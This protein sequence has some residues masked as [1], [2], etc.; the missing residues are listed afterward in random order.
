MK[1][2]LDENL[3][4]KLVPALQ[5]EG[6][7]V[8]SVYTLRMQGLENGELYEFA[9]HSFDLFFTRDRG[10]AISVRQQQPLRV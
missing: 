10:F 7:D 9:R 1:I 3:P 5:A 4:R 8:E 2:L 6:H